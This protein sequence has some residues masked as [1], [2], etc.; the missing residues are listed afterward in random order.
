MFDYEDLDNIP[1]DSLEADPDSR[2]YWTALE[3]EAARRLIEKLLS[4]AREDEKGDLER[5]LARI[6]KAQ[7]RTLRLSDDLDPSNP[8][9]LLPPLHLNRE[10]AEEL[11]RRYGENV[12][13]FAGR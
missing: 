12:A 1:A 5:A 9:G 2:A 6:V 10:D 8:R 3:L 4:L 11:A 13:P 7:A